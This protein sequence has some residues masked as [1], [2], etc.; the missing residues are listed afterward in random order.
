MASGYVCVL[1]G[2]NLDL[3]L[4]AGGEL[5]MAAL[6]AAIDAPVH[7]VTPNADEAA[8]HFAGESRLPPSGRL[9][10]T[11]LRRWSSS[12]VR[13][14]FATPIRGPRSRWSR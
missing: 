14:P 4:T 5:A 3:H 13:P 8:V 7:V 2:I 9:S 1:G 12:R 6:F 11:V 10:H